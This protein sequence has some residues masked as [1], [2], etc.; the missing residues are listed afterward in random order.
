MTPFRLLSVR[1]LC[2]SCTF[3]S[4]QCTTSCTSC[5]KHTA[6]L[7][8]KIFFKHHYQTYSPCTTFHRYQIFSTRSSVICKV[9][10]GYHGTSEIE[11]GLCACT[12]DNPPAK[13]REIIG[14]YLSVQ[15]NKPCS[16]S[17]LEFYM[18]GQRECFNYD[19]V[20]RQETRLVVKYPF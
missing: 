10:I 6:I 2:K 4:L 12:V 16:I 15:A 17:H 14:D 19:S 9:Y 3:Q 1:S 18:F 11:H 8:H 5:V 13:A 20:T 7:L